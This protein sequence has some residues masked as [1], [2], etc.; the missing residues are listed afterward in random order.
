[1]ETSEV[2]VP[3]R[4][5]KLIIEQVKKQ[6]EKYQNAGKSSGFPLHMAVIYT[7]K[8]GHLKLFGSE[9]I[10]TILKEC[11]EPLLCSDVWKAENRAGGTGPT[12]P[13]LVR[14]KILPFMVKAL[15][16]QSFGRT[17]NCQIDALFRWS[18]QSCTSSAASGKYFVS[19]TKR[20][21]HFTKAT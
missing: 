11:G 9:A 16:F 4:T 15:C 20:S 17:N 5:L 6:C 2:N 18:D 10:T 14:P 1:M 12:T 7:N 21:V 13:T 19:T 8:D 3:A